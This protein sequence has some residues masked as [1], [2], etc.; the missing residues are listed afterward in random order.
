MSLG[1]WESPNLGKLRFSLPHK[2]T[3]QAHTSVPTRRPSGPQT[4]AGIQEPSTCTGAGD[5]C[6]NTL[7]Q[8]LLLLESLLPMPAP[9]I[10]IQIIYPTKLSEV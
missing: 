6:I 10:K 5:R 4:C 9:L 1:F 2:H 8:M 7:T 3:S